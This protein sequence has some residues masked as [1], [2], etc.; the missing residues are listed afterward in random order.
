M[1]NLQDALDDLHEQ[2]EM[3]AIRDARWYRRRPARSRAEIVCYVAVVFAFS[4]FMWW[5]WR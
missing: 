4:L 3:N 2:S 1:T 5:I